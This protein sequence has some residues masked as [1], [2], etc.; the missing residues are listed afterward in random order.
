[1]ESEYKSY[2]DLLDTMQESGRMNMYGA[3]QMLREL[4]D[5]L[6]KKQATDIAVAWMK[7]KVLSDD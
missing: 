7:H 2:F 1:M 5:D 3:A 6:N 4:D